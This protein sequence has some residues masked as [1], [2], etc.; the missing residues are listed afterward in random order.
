MGRIFKQC[1]IEH[2]EVLNRPI[3]LVNGTLTW[4]TIKSAPRSN[5]NEDA[6]IGSLKQ[7]PQLHL[8]LIVILRT[9]FFGWGVLF[10]YSVF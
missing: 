7:E 2:V 10:L 9:P 6:L 5:G 1:F 8:Q 3:C 4:S